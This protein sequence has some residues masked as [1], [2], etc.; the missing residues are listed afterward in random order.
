MITYADSNDYT[1][2][3]IANVTLDDYIDLLDKCTRLFYDLFVKYDATHIAVTNWKSYEGTSFI[4]ALESYRCSA[5][6]CP[7]VQELGVTLLGMPVNSNDLAMHW[8]CCGNKFMLENEM[9]FDY[10]FG[11]LYS[12]RLA[13]ANPFDYDLWTTLGGIEVTQAPNS[14]RA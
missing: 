4:N 7:K 3:R 8:K 13:L 11:K 9:H 6:R 1:R 12:T 14:H 5:A 2:E 10:H